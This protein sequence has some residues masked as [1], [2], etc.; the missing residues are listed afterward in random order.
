MGIDNY[1]CRAGHFFGPGSKGKNITLR[2]GR[3]DTCMAIGEIGG[4]V[5]VKEK[6]RP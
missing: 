4:T 1:R 2:D 5:G 3:G 6:A